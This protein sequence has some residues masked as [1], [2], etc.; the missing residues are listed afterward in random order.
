[1][2]D[3]R[4]DIIHQ[5]NKWGA[6]RTPFL[7]IFDFEM[8][9]PL[10]FS[11]KNPLPPSVYYDMQGKTNYTGEWMEVEKPR[12]DICPVSFDQYRKAFDFVQEHQKRGNSYL[13]NLTFP[14][15]LNIN[16]DLKDVFTASKAKYKLLYKDD[17][18]VFSP[19]TFVRIK[20]GQI[21]S[22][23][24]KGTIDAS[25]P[26]AEEIIL[27]DAKEKA[28]HNTIVD[29][30][31]NDLSMVANNVRV[32]KFRYI[33]HLKTSMKNLLQVSSEIAGDLPVDYHRNIGDMLWKLLPAGSISGAPKKKTVEIIQEAEIDERG[34]Y[35]GISGVF[36]GY[37]LD[38]FVMIRFIEKL[39]EDYFYRSGG[40][41][42][43]RSEVEKEYRE[44]IDKVYVP[45]V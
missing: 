37:S 23:P 38:S 22:Y 33:D 21:F 10:A 44:L 30:I 26:N 40:G 8:K 28:E 25:I 11:L 20:D 14:T 3:P 15:L 12:I 9:K 1:M 39:G 16:M 31:R 42:T 29:L 6:Q 17:F 34:Y 18:V 19:E 2:I 32:E 24:M 13:S 7:F 35:S 5:L 27:E 4:P 41:I 45:V 36:D 43:I